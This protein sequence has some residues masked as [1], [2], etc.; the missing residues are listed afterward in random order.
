M[1]FTSIYSQTE[2]GTIM[3]GGSGSAW[4]SKDEIILPDNNFIF[5]NSGILVHP[6]ASYFFLDDLAI[7]IATRLGLSYSKIPSNPPLERTVNF[8]LG[9][10][11]RYYFP[12]QRLAIFPQLQYLIGQEYNR[13]EILNPITNLYET[14]RTNSTNGN[15]HMGI[16]VA[17]FITKSISVEG[18]FSYNTYK[19]LNETPPNGQVPFTDPRHFSLNFNLGMQL[20]LNTKQAKSSKDVE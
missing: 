14:E 2:K 20:Y 6:N 1:F 10:Q 16:G 18:L 15:F 13:N 17:Y 12:I 9:P 3:F 7:G 8:A 11:I 5:R 4:S 19:I